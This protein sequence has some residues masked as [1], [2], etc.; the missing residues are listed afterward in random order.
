MRQS[1]Q[2]GIRAIELL[3]T[4]ADTKSAN[5]LDACVSTLYNRGEARRG[6]NHV[7]EEEEVRL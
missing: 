6:T 3:Q 5:V 4:N 1:I 7:A 2:R